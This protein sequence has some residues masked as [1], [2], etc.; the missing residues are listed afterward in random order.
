VPE[1][2]GSRVDIGA[3]EYAGEA[4]PE[5]HAPVLAPIGNKQVNEGDLLEFTIIA[6][7]PDGDAL[8]FN[9]SNLPSG[10]ILLDNDNG[11][12]TFSW[13]PTYEQAEVY[14]AVHFEVSDGQLSDSEDISITVNNVN[15]PPSFLN[16]LTTDYSVDE[17][18]NLNIQLAAQD[19]DTA[20]TVQ[21]SVLTKPSWVSLVANSPGNPANLQLR[22]APGYDIAPVAAP[23]TIRATD[24]QGAFVEVTLN[25][26]VNNVNRPPT[27]S[28]VA[29]QVAVV[30]KNFR[31]TIT[32]SDLD[33]ERVYLNP[34]ILP[35]WLTL[36][37]NGNNTATLS[38][39]PRR[40]NLG[41]HIVKI[42][43]SDGAAKA[44]LQFTVKV[45]LK[46]LPPPVLDSGISDSK[47]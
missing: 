30:N 5:D 46:N 20:D 1:G 42:E 37:D 7:D 4:P 6:S 11:G 14:T 16:P 43:A 31:L 47:R 19:P 33:G 39:T 9:V 26:T 15:R 21:I 13:T 23:V 38:G 10:A 34:V 27:I 28:P 44:T 3:F 8:D 36:T 45:R 32:A 35:S 2:G 18:A 17:G 22:A 41:N 12:V 40:A 29:N 24:N 25:I